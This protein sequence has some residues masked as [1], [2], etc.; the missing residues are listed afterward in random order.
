MWYERTELLLGA[1][2]LQRLDQACV[3]VIGIGGN[4]P[5]VIYIVAAGADAEITHRIGSH[6]AS[7][8]E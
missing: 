4:G 1:D 8:G 2:N 7:V 5:A 6:R 3:A